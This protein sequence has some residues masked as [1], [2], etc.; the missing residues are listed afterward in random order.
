MKF[1]T[2]KRWWGQDCFFSLGLGFFSLGLTLVLGL[3]LELLISLACLVKAMICCCISLSFILVGS[4][5]SK[6]LIELFFMKLN[7]IKYTISR[8]TRLQ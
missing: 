4:S 1:I 7:N 3:G 6:L 8:E 5:R 2:V